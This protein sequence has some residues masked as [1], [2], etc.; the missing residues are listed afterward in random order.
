MSSSVP[1]ITLPELFEN[2]DKVIHAG[3]FGL[4][5]LVAWRVFS[6]W[7]RLTY[8]KLLALIFTSLYGVLDE[9]HQSF[10]IGRNSDTMDW[11]ADTLGALIALS[12]LKYFQKRAAKH[13]EPP[14]DCHEMQLLPVGQLDL[15]DSVH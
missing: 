8:V 6:L 4:L 7:S 3:V 5:S 10:V 12:L 2:Q 14:P 1:H 11:L 9:W 15:H 13:N